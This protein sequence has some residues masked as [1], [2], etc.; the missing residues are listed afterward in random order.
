MSSIR[1]KAPQPDRGHF[2]VRRTFLE[3]PDEAAWASDPESA[4]VGGA[5]ARAH[6]D[7]ALHRRAETPTL[8]SAADP[9]L[10][11]EFELVGLSS[12][13]DCG[14]ACNDGQC[15]C[16]FGGS[17]MLEPTG[18]SDAATLSD[19]V[20]ASSGRLESGPR[21]VAGSWD[22]DA[23][24]LDPSPGSS[25][26]LEEMARLAQ[27]NARLALENQW[28]RDGARQPPATSDTSAEVEI[29]GKQRP[30]QLPPGTWFGGYSGA[31]VGVPYGWAV[32]LDSLLWFA[33]A[34]GLAEVA[35]PAKDAPG[36]RRRRRKCVA[37]AGDAAQVAPGE[38]VGEEGRTTV[39]LRNVPNDY[40]R[41]MLLD[42]LDDEGFKALYDF[43]YL[44]IDARRRRA[45]GMRS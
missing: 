5:R 29:Q 24:S 21:S 42:M 19:G 45:S 40:T 26:V 14:D 12:S 10:P 11:V 15:S 43:V 38:E 32:P 1:S 25:S 37:A 36:K 18:W 33:P 31:E 8:S 30:P 20:T 13:K 27:E 23:D 28:L 16:R 44:P 17:P 6:S 22:Q 4:F 7:S 34:V 9:R 2:V 39:M 3:V 35:E 41:Q